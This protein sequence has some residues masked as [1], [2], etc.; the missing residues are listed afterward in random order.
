MA[1]SQRPSV[2]QLDGS[3]AHFWIRK[4]RIGWCADTGMS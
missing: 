3:H 1:A 2:R 4:G